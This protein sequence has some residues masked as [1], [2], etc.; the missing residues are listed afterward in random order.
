MMMKLELVSGNVSG[1]CPGSILRP[2]Q[3]TSDRTYHITVICPGPAASQE[4][5]RFRKSGNRRRVNL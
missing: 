1:W 3:S 2:C 4:G 5:L